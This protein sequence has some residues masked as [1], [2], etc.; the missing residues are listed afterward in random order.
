MALTFSTRRRAKPT[1]GLARPTI[2]DVA[3]R[4]GVSVG[5]VSHVLNES[6]EVSRERQDRVLAAVEQ[7]GYVPN[8]LAQSLRRSHSRVIGVCIPDT[9]F[10]YF[11]ALAAGVETLAAAEGY[12]VMHVFSLQDSATEL[13]RVRMLLKYRIGGMLLL[14][15][16][17]PQ[18]TLN[19]LADA[20][21]PTVILDRPIDDRRF[22][23]AMV[24]L[25][26]ATMHAA[27]H[28]LALG[29][30]RLLLLTGN[31]RWLISQR[32]IEGIRLALRRS[33][34]GGTLRVLDR[35]PDIEGLLAQLAPVLRGRDAP[36]AVITTN[37]LAVAGVLQ[38]L[39]RLGLRCPQDIS[40]LA[41]DE[42]RWAGLVD[43]TLAVIHAPAEEM[44]RQG[45]A[46]LRARIA[47]DAGRPKRIALEAELRPGGSIG[48]APT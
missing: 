5:T 33:G 39:R 40:L 22:D 3:K 15:T 23:Q 32:R 16:A 35:A 25:R 26:S 6:R 41:A 13:R 8:M 48:A 1:E 47:G 34:P 27:E 44:A 11:A 20:A 14:P 37:S 28:L 24:D 42:P 19:C 17:T 31:Q 7:L 36:T 38:V 21:V 43:P 46:L 18:E 29:H 10:S 30:R 9:S 12:E 4:A 45:W 2:G